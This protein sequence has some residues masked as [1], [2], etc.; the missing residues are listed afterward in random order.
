MWKKKPVERSAGF[1]LQVR[2]FCN[3][4]SLKI[5]RFPI[6]R[7]ES[8]FSHLFFCRL[9]FHFA[10]QRI[11][12]FLQLFDLLFLEKNMFRQQIYCGL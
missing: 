6:R 5:F 12:L 10:F 9:F 3:L 2:V 8:R 4:Y 1:V 7:C 11:I